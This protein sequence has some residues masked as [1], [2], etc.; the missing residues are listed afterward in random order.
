MTERVPCD[1]EVWEAPRY[2]HSH[3]CQAKAK[4]STT[5]DGHTRCL[6][7]VH[8]NVRKRLAAR[9]KKQYDEVAL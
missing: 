7:G 5:L 9:Y 3:A 8:R 6:C 2:W 4:W 1:E